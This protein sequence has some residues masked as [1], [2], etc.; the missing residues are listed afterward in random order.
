MAHGF[1]F[2]E[3][4]LPPSPLCIWVEL[5]LLADP[6]WAVAAL[7]QLEH[8]I[9]LAKWQAPGPSQAL[10]ADESQSPGLG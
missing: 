7:S 9:T 10:G 1:K 6:W 3:F 8:L 5:I 4:T 2:G